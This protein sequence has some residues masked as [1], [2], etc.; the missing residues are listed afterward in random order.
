MTEQAPSPTA[1]LGAAIRVQRRRLGLQ[2]AVLADLAGVGVAFIYDLEKGKPTLRIDKVLAVLGALGLG[3]SV[4]PSASLMRSELPSA[5]AMSV[6]G[7]A[8]DPA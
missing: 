6:E 7:D 5:D 1:V 8:G 3:L 4:G 2:Q